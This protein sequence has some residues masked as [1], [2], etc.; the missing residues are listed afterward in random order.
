M[1]LEVACPILNRP[2]PTPTPTPSSYGRSMT[3]KLSS[4][5]QEDGNRR[6]CW[7]QIDIKNQRNKCKIKRMKN[8]KTCSE[9][10]LSQLKYRGVTV[11][12]ISM[13][14]AIPISIPILYSTIFP[15]NP[16][17]DPGL[18]GLR[19][20]GIPSYAGGYSRLLLSRIQSM[21]D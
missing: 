9:R 11:F 16:N 21:Q 12:S 14:L 17:L 18:L 19:L 7:R 15:V 4:L 8:M 2:R 13:S 10:D 3:K 1:S 5:R 20:S 6:I